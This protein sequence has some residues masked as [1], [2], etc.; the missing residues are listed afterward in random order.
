MQPARDAWS[1]AD[2][3][4]VVRSPA[5]HWALPAERVKR[6]VLESEWTGEPPFDICG[7][8]N[9]GAD[10]ASNDARVLVLEA[11]GGQLPIRAASP[12]ELERFA[13]EQL[14]PL[15]EWVTVPSFRKKVQSI[16]LGADGPLRIFVLAL[17]ELASAVEA[18]RA[19]ESSS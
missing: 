16:V 13:A 12:V 4:L 2:Q 6:I 8:L 10:V 3:Y 17:P 15:P 9:V 18:R 5:F 1:A 11:P 7:Y 19:E 14:A